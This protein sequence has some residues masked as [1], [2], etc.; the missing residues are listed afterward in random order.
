MDWFLGIILSP[1]RALTALLHAERSGD[2]DELR[3]ARYRFRKLAEGLPAVLLG[4]A[5]VVWLIWGVAHGGGR[6]TDYYRSQLEQATTTG[7]LRLGEICLRRLRELQPN[8]RSYV[9]A[10]AKLH[11]LRGESRR[12]AAMMY[13]LAPKPEGGYPPAQLWIAEQLV[14]SPENRTRESVEECYLRLRA[15]RQSAELAEASAAAQARL[16]LIL[17][18]RAEIEADPQLRAAV[19][20]NPHL[21]LMQAERL[22]QSGKRRE[23]MR[24][25][26]AVIPYF[27]K[28]LAAKPG[29]ESL[30]QHLVSAYSLTKQFQRAVRLLSAVV[31]Q[32]DADP[33]L[34]LRFI[35]V[36]LDWANE[37]VLDPQM[38]PERKGDVFRAALKAIVDLAAD[39]TEYQIEM[40]RLEERLGKIDEAE[41][42]Y[43][44]AIEQYPPRRIEL[45][46]FYLRHNRRSDGLQQ[47]DLAYR[48]LKA[49]YEKRPADAT[50]AVLLADAAVILGRYA[51]AVDVLE[52]AQRMFPQES[53]FRTALCQ[54]WLQWWKS[55]LPAGDGNPPDPQLLEN[56]VRAEPWNLDLLA[57]LMDVLRRKD[58][59]SA[60][61]SSVLESMLVR[62]D[63][64][65]VAH[66][67]LG[68]EAV[69]RGETAQGIKHLE[70]A[71][72][73]DPSLAEA[74]NNLAFTLASQPQPD[75]PR[76]L[77][78]VESALDKMP[79]NWE[80]LRTRGQIL[81][82]LGRGKAALADLQQ[83]LAI[84]PNEPELHQQLAKA[85]RVEGLTDLADHHDRIAR[86]L[87]S[88]PL[89]R[90]PPR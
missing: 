83:C 58:R 33:A 64:P 74:A 21:L 29:D 71:L 77:Q 66:L 4:G 23:S 39:R 89:P 12:A 36:C 90:T 18:R 73:L 47:A 49:N 75:L 27:E 37:A 38:P 8:D 10:M 51:E 24:D 55:Q 25:A 31:S 52:A 11:A 59:S 32:S 88:G 82:Q 84:N 28:E 65:A 61:A 53:G 13:D 54:T 40:A 30:R 34:R 2:R 9:F 43:L 67:I 3:E 20:A 78:L 56:A 44:A 87:S 60:Q 14:R 50:N 6:L 80:F 7:D 41:R 35:R 69:G 57:T 16:C 26:A 19:A 15:A 46:R 68:T 17:D 85:Y 76:A 45:V 63:A 72:E 42:D 5:L 22:A 70:L 48:E 79:E 81:L 86:E 1:F 62:G